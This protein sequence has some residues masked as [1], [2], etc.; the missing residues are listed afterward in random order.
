MGI[1]VLSGLDSE[2]EEHVAVWVALE[3][4]E[5][6]A[7]SGEDRALDHHERSEAELIQ[8]FWDDAG[9][10]TPASRFWEA[11]TPATSGEQTDGDYLCRKSKTVQSKPTCSV[12][13]DRRAAEE[14]A[15]QNGAVARAVTTETNHAATGSGRLY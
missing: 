9:F 15:A 12:F 1:V 7:P 6:E 14:D 11:G 8:E 2:E 5:E 3:S 13:A 10:P 4:L